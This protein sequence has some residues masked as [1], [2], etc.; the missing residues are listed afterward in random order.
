MREERTALSPQDRE[1]LKVLREIE[2]GHLKQAAAAEPTP[3][4]GTQRAELRN[5]ARAVAGD[6]APG[7][8]QHCPRPDQRQ[9]PLRLRATFPSPA[10]APCSFNTQ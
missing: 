3:V 10:T 8:H 1:R 5:L 4:A 9:A 6:G 2:Q 7:F